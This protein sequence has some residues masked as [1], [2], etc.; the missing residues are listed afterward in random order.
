MPDRANR[1]LA[2]ARE[3]YQ[4]AVIILLGTRREKQELGAGEFLLRY[5][6]L[7]DM[8]T[9]RWSSIEDAQGLPSPDQVLT[10]I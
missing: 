6:A 8:V 1:K 10:W 3:A 5:K 4:Q 7:A 2:S 9:A